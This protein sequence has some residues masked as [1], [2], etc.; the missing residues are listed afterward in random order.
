[1]K[2]VSINALNFILI[3]IFITGCNQSGKSP[4][5]DNNELT[6]A[7]DFTITDLQG[8]TLRLSDYQGK[9]VILDIWDTW[10][11]P[12][13]KGIPDFIEFYKKYQHKN[14]VV[15]GLALG[16]EGEEKVKS[17]AA[18][19]NIPYSLAIADSSVLNAYGPIQGIPTTLIINQKGRI[20][21][22]Y[23]GFRE[24]DVFEKAIQAL[25]NE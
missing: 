2:C 6:T 13:R 8:D 14:F 10:C 12:C 4:S 20:V 15:V 18:E 11:P 16:R 5:Q 24:K 22:R 1:M 17:F 23:V 25:L 7:P 9:V 21:N 3:L 19:Q